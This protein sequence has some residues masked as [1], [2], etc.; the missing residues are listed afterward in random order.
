MGDELSTLR[1]VE[2][3]LAAGYRPTVYRGVAPPP[4][5]GRGS[6]VL[7]VFDPFDFHTPGLGLRQA[8]RWPLCM[9]CYHAAGWLALC[10]SL[11]R[12]TVEGTSAT[13]PIPA[14][15]LLFTARVGG[16][17]WS[18]ATHHLCPDPFKAATRALLLAAGRPTGSSPR[19]NHLAALPQGVLLHVLQLAAEPIYDCMS[20]RQ[21]RCFESPLL[22][23][24]FRFDT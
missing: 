11:R 9:H 5:L 2:A 18:P 21:S 14:C 1:V 20:W 13:A 17:L 24:S 6:G 19:A 10:A 15:R 16:T 3:L 7:E 22:H 4:F 23:L 12:A 8:R